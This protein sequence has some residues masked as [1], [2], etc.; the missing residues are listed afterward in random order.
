MSSTGNAGAHRTSLETRRAFTETYGFLKYLT[1]Y[2]LT[3]IAS[4]SA[5][6]CSALAHSWHAHNEIKYTI[7][8]PQALGV[9]YP[10]AAAPIASRVISKQYNAKRELVDSSA[11]RPLYCVICG[12]ISVW[13]HIN[14]VW[15]HLEGVVWIFGVIRAFVF[16]VTCVCGRFNA[17]S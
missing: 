9:R 1:L 17:S 13:C 4:A 6:G 5:L 16:A 8:H 7:Y 3:V 15:C 2:V 14:S 11:G 10:P 12:Y